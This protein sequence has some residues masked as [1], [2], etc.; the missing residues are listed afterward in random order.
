M[1]KPYNDKK[2]QLGEPYASMLQ[3]FCTAN[4]GAPA[5]NI[6]REALKEHIERRLEK[7]ELKERFESARRERPNVPKKNVRLIQK[8]C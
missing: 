5:L 1:A 6:I 8:D 7:P 4:Y 3:D 2:L